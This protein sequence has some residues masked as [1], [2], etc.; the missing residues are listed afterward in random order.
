MKKIDLTKD[1]NMLF[2][3]GAAIGALLFIITYGTAIL[4]PGYD[5]W[6]LN[7]P[8]IDIR[9]HYIGF[10]NFIN[11]PWTF[12]IGNTDSLSY[13]H[14]MSVVWTDSIPGLCV[15]A[16]LIRFALPKTP[17][18]FGIYGII[19]FALNGAFA[20][21]LVYEVTKNAAVSLFSSPFFIMSFTVIHRMYYHTA[22]ASHWIILAALLYFYTDRKYSIKRDAVIYGLFSFLCVSIHSY[23]LPMAGGILLFDTIYIN[24]EKKKKTLSM[25]IPLAS[26][27]VSGILSLLVYGAFTSQV[28]HGG[29][30]IGEFYC[31][32]NTLFNSLGYGMLPKLPLVRDTQYE[33]FG[34]LGLGI[35]VLCVICGAYLIYRA[36]RLGFKGTKEFLKEHLRITL[37][38]IMGLFF[39]AISIFPEVDF[40]STVI[41]PDILPFAIKK[42]FGI[43]RSNGRF[44][45]PL[46]YIIMLSC[47]YILFRMTKKAPVAYILL[48]VCL[49]LQGADLKTW[50][51]EKHEFYT[52]EYKYKNFLDK[53][54]PDPDTYDHIVMTY[55]NGDMKMET[56]YYAANHDKTINMF[57]FARVI[58]NIENAQLEKYKE[59]ALSGNPEPGCIY[60]FND[61]SLKEWEGADLTI[62]K[63]RD[64]LYIGY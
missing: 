64:D 51:N 42:L 6:I 61:E 26:F 8:D 63:I 19:T 33:G 14:M 30:A 21:L 24:R 29:F 13:P 45:W 2:F 36:V 39:A 31:N 10:L 46:M 35:L 22:L 17:Q 28:E 52:A 44:I 9:Q 4:D 32:L 53:H 59:A 23:F 15:L 40:G 56:G 54:G 43:F 38:I 57:Y 34:Y 60:L 20:A 1:R 37:S 47:I 25:L 3:F 11:D 18:I 7:S 27:C 12:P 48:A 41:I 58:D 50:V 49:L 62:E 5:A 55:D 16:K